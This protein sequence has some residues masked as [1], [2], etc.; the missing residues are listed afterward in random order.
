[1]ANSNFQKTKTNPHATTARVNALMH[2]MSSIEKEKTSFCQ[3]R[4]HYL[5]YNILQN[6]AQDKWK[7]RVRYGLDKEN[8]RP[9][10]LWVRDVTS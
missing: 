7:C 10:Q 4:S 6:S 9:K 8:N 2:S 1:M 5:L 3:G